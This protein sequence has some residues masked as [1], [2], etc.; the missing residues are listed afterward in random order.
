MNAVVEKWIND[1]ADFFSNALQEFQSQANDEMEVFAVDCHPWNGV[2]VLA[3][4]THSE[5]E[6]SPFLAEV[7]EMAAWR[8][9]D[10][11]SGLSCLQRASDL[12]SQMRDVYE[13]AGE[14]RSRVGERF[15][16]GC[17]AAVAAKRV[18]EV[19]SKYKLSCSFKITI[20]H[21]DSEKDYYPPG[22]RKGD[23]VD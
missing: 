6:E 2:L 16:E 21:P 9:Y 13:Q 7:G 14:D 1:V 18:Q 11:A 19:L 12:G 23:I 10:F 4:L 17:A 3:F 15:L 5:V 20:P 8:N 22:K